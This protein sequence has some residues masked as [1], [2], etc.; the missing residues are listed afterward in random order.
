MLGGVE[1]WYINVNDQR[2]RI[3]CVKVRKYMTSFYVTLLVVIRP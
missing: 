2:P 3:N 1:T